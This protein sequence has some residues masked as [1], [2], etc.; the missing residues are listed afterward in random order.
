[1]T[2]LGLSLQIVPMSL[3]RVFRM[4]WMSCKTQ[5]FAW[6]AGHVNISSAISLALDLIVSGSG[7]NVPETHFFCGEGRGERNR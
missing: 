3:P 6:K 5:Q 2:L 4:L 7:W 1:M